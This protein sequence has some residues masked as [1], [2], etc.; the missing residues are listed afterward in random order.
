MSRRRRSRGERGRRVGGG[1]G[2]GGSTDD[3]DQMWTTSI[4]IPKTRHFVQ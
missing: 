4:R 3:C 2:G 1:G